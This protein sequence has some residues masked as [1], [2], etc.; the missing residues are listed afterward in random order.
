MRTIDVTIN[1]ARLKSIS[2]VFP[3]DENALPD[4]SAT[5]Q[6]YSGMTELAEFTVST[7]QYYKNYVKDK[8]MD[9]PARMLFPITELRGDI[10]EIV[11][12]K[13]QQTMN[14]LPP[15]AEVVVEEDP[16]A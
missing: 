9:L 14:Q 3:L 4:V 8:Y 16:D 15:M 6:L 7:Q 5:L 11:A 1:K 12:A 2:I 10:E 13:A